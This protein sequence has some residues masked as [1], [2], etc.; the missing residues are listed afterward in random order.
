M[1]GRLQA[2]RVTALL[3]GLG[4]AAT[5][6][7]EVEALTARLGRSM[8]RARA[9]YER[10]RGW[11]VRSFFRCGLVEMASLD[12]QAAEVFAT[13]APQATAVQ[14]ERLLE[15]AR[16]HLHHARTGYRH[17]IDVKAETMLCMADAR[18]G[19]DE[20]TRALGALPE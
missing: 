10:V 2:A 8:A 18:E 3:D 1:L 9:A 7:G 4:R 6:R 17:A 19:R 16:T 14:R 12:R 5:S 11:G 15:R 20:A 13:R